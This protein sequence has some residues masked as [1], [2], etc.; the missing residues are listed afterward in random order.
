MGDTILPQKRRMQP[1]ANSTLL[2]P[3]NPQP[4]KVDLLLITLP[5]RNPH[6]YYATQVPEAL[7]RLSISVEQAGFSAYCLDLDNPYFKKVFARRDIIDELDEYFRNI[8][9]RKFYQAYD[10]L[11]PQAM[12][13]YESYLDEC[14]ERISKIDH[15]WLG[16][17]IFSEQ[18]ARCSIDFMERVRKR[19]PASKIVIGGYC[20]VTP[21]VH[22][23]GHVLATGEPFKRLGQYIRDKGLC[24]YFVVGEGE[25]ALIEI[26]KGN[27]KYPGINTYFPKQIDDLDA[28][29]IPDYHDFSMRDYIFP[30]PE[31]LPNLLFPMISV[32]GSRGCVR[33]CIFCDIN[34]KWPKYRWVSPT[35]LAGEIIHYYEEYGVLNFHWSDSLV[36][37]SPPKMHEFMKILADY[38]EKHD[39]RFWQTGSFIVREDYQM[40]EEMWATLKKAGFDVCVFGLESG[41]EKVR[42][43]MHKKFSNEAVRYTVE[44]CRKY[45]IECQFLIIVGYP[46][47]T[48][49]DYFD[50]LR[51]MEEFAPRYPGDRSV[52]FSL[53]SFGFEYDWDETPLN[54]DPSIHG[55][56]HD[57]EIGWK[58]PITN[59]Y[60][61]LK[62]TQ[63]IYEFLDQLGYPIYGE[64][65]HENQVDVDFLETNLKLS[66][67][68][69]E[70][71]QDIELALPQKKA[72]YYS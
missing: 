35:K 27:D 30:N 19:L 72:G 54:R 15:E 37:A 48:Q 7:G 36:N 41:S 8:N 39:V 5:R 61:A 52:I 17:S 23:S 28:L 60:I 33:N 56:T 46:T 20:M 59:N 10:R 49:E 50:T 12:E 26:M 3:K 70:I 22:H 66:G 2:R 29:P 47:E 24:D 4:D 1:L 42:Y 63:A 11:T 65:E 43:E 38:S 25:V 18:S 67:R 51:M 58:S 14:V 71:L 6:I 44:M 68:D 13:F 21:A 16:I 69:S 57:P 34:T 62:R 31:D 45:E 40:P 32:T 9:D 55:I 53:S 64:W